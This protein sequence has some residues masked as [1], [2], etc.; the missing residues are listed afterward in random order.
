[1]ELFDNHGS[2]GHVLI[3]GILLERSFFSRTPSNDRQP[4]TNFR[5]RIFK[6]NRMIST[7]QLRVY[8]IT[9]VS[10]VY[11]DDVTVFGI[12]SQFPECAGDID[13]DSDV[14]ADDLWH[15]S[16]NFGMTCRQE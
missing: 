16:T 5:E 9:N 7:I 3:D 15:L 14:D 13:G 1:M 10:E 2:K 6:I 4:D 11:I 8:D 12:S